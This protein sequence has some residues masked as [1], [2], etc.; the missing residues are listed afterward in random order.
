MA[1]Q[2]NQVMQRLFQEII[3]SIDVVQTG[4]LRNRNPKGT[5]GKGGKQC[6][7]MDCPNCGKEGIGRAFYYANDYSIKCNRI[8]ECSPTSI[9]EALIIDGFSKRDI[10][11]NL[12]AAAG[13]SIPDSR[14]TMSEVNFFK[15]VQ[16][17]LVGALQSN[18][19]VKS[20]FCQSRNLSEDELTKLGYGYY[21]STGYIKAALLK[22]NLSIEKAESIGLLKT[23][24][25]DY[26]RF[27]GRITGFWN[28]PDG[29]YR[30]WGRLP[31]KTLAPTE[32]YKPRKYMFT[33][34]KC[35]FNKNAPYM[36][37]RREKGHLHL[38]EGMLDADSL[39]LSKQLWSAAVGA[40]HINE[41][42]A[43]Y[44]ASQNIT[45]AVFLADGDAAG[46]EGAIKSIFN[47][48]PLGISLSICALSESDE[49]V[50]A[51]RAKGD[52]RRLDS[53]LANARSS[54]SYLAD[55]YTKSVSYQNSV[56][57][58]QIESGTILLSSKTRSMLNTIL[59]QR[60]LSLSPELTAV[61]TCH[62]LMLGGLD[63]NE[64][65]AV[66]RRRLGFTVDLV[67]EP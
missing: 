19:A 48:E 10:V 11:E 43:V 41:D 22:S 67:R 25:E 6:Y 33:P 5:I 15:S 64:A 21:P 60:G 66:V 7:S 62:H 31:T 20:S 52:T 39:W 37:S 46:T 36:F 1:I 57:L 2:T 3:P 12:Y 40:N 50:D 56:F 4:M 30:V 24:D 59:D 16:R 63:F 42:Q 53:L 13:Q 9:W 58:R 51:L 55:V 27:R 32:K 8:E 45:T 65:S 14:N 47:C 35:G 49:D 54:A 61:S 38:M 29:S 26:D 17:I 23:A 28:L 44:L 18:Q 34:V